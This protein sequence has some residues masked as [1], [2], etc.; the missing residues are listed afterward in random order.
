M[1]SINY[2]IIQQVPVVPT[3]A[4]TSS[5]IFGLSQSLDITNDFEFSPPHQ[6]HPSLIPSHPSSSITTPPLLQAFTIPPLTQAFTIPPLT[7]AIPTTPLLQ[8]VTTPPLLQAVTTPPLLQAVPTPPLTQAVT[9]PPLLQAVTTPPLLQ[10]VPT[11]PLTQAVPTPPLTQAV[12]TPPL[13]QPV[14]A[15]HALQ[16]S[17]EVEQRDSTSQQENDNDDLEA[18]METSR[19]QLIEQRNEQEVW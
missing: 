8:A 11:P 2:F 17:G 18:L 3:T 6:T 7:Q 9:T 13:L 5:N 4:T 10:A 14:I 16:T 15:P 1:Y 12:T 19:N